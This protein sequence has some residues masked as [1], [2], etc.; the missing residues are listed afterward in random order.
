MNLG[1]VGSDALYGSQT[2]NA[3]Y[4]QVEGGRKFE[5]ATGATPNRRLEV[6]IRVYM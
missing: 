5:I 1:F 3:G 2:L 6:A 4:I